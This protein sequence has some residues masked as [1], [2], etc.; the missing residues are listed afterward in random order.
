MPGRPEPPTAGDLRLTK[1]GAWG[2]ESPELFVGLSLL[3]PIGLA[4]A[5]VALGIP[6]ALGMVLAMASI[7]GQVVINDAMI[8]RYVAPH[9]RAKAFGLRYFLGFGVSGL[10]VPM[11]AVLHSLG[12]FP[13]VLGVTTLFGVA[14]VASAI[15]FFAL[16]RRPASEAVAG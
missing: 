9:L 4:L 10:A 6:M 13:A 16:T 12:G 11:I 3:Q 7:Y 8:A 2:I 15:G 5:T 14:V 1:G